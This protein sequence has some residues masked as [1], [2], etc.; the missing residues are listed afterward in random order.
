MNS[1]K[2]YGTN[3]E[4]SKVAEAISISAGTTDQNVYE[5]ALTDQEVDIVLA[6]TSSGSGSISID[7]EYSYGLDDT[8]TRKW[9]SVGAKTTVDGEFTLSKPVEKVRVLVSETGG[10]NGITLDA[11]WRSAFSAK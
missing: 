1:S 2:L 10:T 3:R 4:N 9:F 11:L 5:A 7:V 6:Y 8:G